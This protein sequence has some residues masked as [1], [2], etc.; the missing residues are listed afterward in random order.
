MKQQNLEGFFCFV[1]FFG[2][3]YIFKIRNYLCL[4]IQLLIDYYQDLYNQFN[5]ILDGNC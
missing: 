2:P 1:F 3:M 4:T 5:V